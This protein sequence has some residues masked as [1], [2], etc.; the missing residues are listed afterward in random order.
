MKHS[1]LKDLVKQLNNLKLEGIEQL[2]IVGVKGSVLEENFL[3]AI[4]EVDE[5]G[6]TDKLTDSLVDGYNALA[7]DD[8]E[9]DAPE[10]AEEAP[11]E[12]KPKSEKDKVKSSQKKAASKGVGKNKG[13][14]R[15]RYGHVQS[16]ISGKLDDLLFAG[17]TVAAMMKELNIKRTR[18]IGHMKSL[19]NDKGLKVTET[20]PE[21]KDVKLNDTH[22]QVE[23]EFWTKD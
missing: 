16:A 12:E 4:E 7:K 6:M 11:Q 20:V 21:G 13:E 9:E 3:T 1:D 8:G 18:V 17:N 10:T 5:K 15:S 2:R 23:E 14:K 19:K 22:Y